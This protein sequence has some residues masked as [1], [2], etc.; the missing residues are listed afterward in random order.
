MRRT[1][2]KGMP[3]T[4]ALLLGVA[5]AALAAASDV[6]PVDDPRVSDSREVAARLATALK[7]E[8]QAAMAEVGPVGAIAVCRDRAPRIAAD[9][10]TETG[11]RVSRTST[12]LR[13]IGNAPTPAQ[14]AGLEA[15]AKRAAA[16]ADIAGLEYTDTVVTP[17]GRR[18]L[19]MKA[20]QTNAVCLVCHGE[21]I[22]PDVAAAID[23]LYPEDRARGHRLGE[24]RGAFVVEWP[25][26]G[27]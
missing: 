22:P 14:L 19:Y 7:G 18:F 6:E 23:R 3:G 5:L 17:D 24:L 9:L 4:A 11:A 2:R 12:R 27:S 20:I 16:G 25:D 15:M 8:L 1:V 13:N 21:T 26:A 10:S